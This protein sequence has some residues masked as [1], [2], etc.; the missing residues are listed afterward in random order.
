MPDEI[1]RLEQQVI[2]T[3]DLPATFGAAFDDQRRRLMYAHLSTV[4]GS[5]FR[6]AVGVPPT[7]GSISQA[8]PAAASRG[9]TR[10]PPGCCSTW[11]GIAAPDSG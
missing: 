7:A 3:E 10:T 4:S 8:D 6:E 11:P 5:L 9:L 2:A 1:Y